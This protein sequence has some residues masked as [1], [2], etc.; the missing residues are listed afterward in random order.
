V[1]SEILFRCPSASKGGILSDKIIARKTKVIELNMIITTTMI[2]AMMVM[3]MMMIMILMKV[4]QT[5]T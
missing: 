2:M 4:L 3:M 1:I 5:E